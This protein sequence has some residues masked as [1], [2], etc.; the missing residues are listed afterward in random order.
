MSQTTNTNETEI[1]AISGDNLKSAGTLSFVRISGA[2]DYAKL[3][4]AWAANDLDAEL[5][6]ELPTDAVACSRAVKDQTSTDRLARILRRPKQANG[7][8][9]VDETTDRTLHHSV[10][11]HVFPNAIG[12]LG[13]EAQNGT[14]V[15]PLPYGTNLEQL[16]ASVN[17]RYAH[18]MDHLS[19]GDV[20]GWFVSLCRSQDAVA[21]RDTG[22]FYFIPAHNVPTW[23]R[24]VKAI[25][26]GS[27]HG[28]GMIQAMT[29]DDAVAT[30]LDSLTS[31]AETVADELFRGVVDGELGQRALLNRG[32]RCSALVAKVKQYEALLGVSLKTLR[33]RLGGLQTSLSAATLVATPDSKATGALAL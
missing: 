4:T 19:T 23:D 1:I 17:E 28:V 9:L 32:D 15:S 31:E 33:E 20:S 14:K 13:F 22:G 16:A 25:R 24:M 18:H 12:R 10:A 21:L 3:A 30:I 5:L 29:T 6:P 11:L 26:E 2:T 8:A 27:D 7:W